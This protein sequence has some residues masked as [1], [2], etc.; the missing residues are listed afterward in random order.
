MHFADES[1]RERE[2]L[3]SF[4]PMHH[5]VDVIG[6]LAYVIDRLA[7]R[8]LGLERQKVRERRLGTFDLRGKNRFFAHVH[9]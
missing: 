4:D 3:K 5:C 8:G 6:N 7:S 9:V 2:C 1:Q